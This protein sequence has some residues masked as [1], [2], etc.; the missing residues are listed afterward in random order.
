ML[1]RDDNFILILTAV[2]RSLLITL[3]TLF[4]YGC[5]TTTGGIGKYGE[6]LDVNT[7]EGADKEHKDI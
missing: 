3:L 5:A 4:L 2:F 1:L 6:D 7:C